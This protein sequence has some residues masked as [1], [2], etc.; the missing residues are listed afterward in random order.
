MR[1]KLFGILL[2]VLMFVTLL[3]ITVFAKDISTIGDVLETVEGGFPTTPD[4]GW[5]SGDNRLFLNETKMDIV[6]KGFDEGS[7]AQKSD[8]VTKSGNSYIFNPQYGATLSFNMSEGDVLTLKSITITEDETYNGT[9]IPQTPVAQIGDSYYYTLSDALADAEKLETVVLL[10]DIDTDEDIIV[11]ELVFLDLNNHTIIT[12]GKVVNNGTIIV[13][14]ENAPIIDYLLYDVLGN[15]ATG[16]ELTLPDSTDPKYIVPYRTFMTAD[17]ND[18]GDQILKFAIG[19]EYLVWNA[20]VKKDTA[21]FVTYSLALGGDLLASDDYE[22]ETIVETT[23]LKLNND[24]TIGSNDETKGYVELYVKDIYDDDPDLAKTGSIDLNSHK[25]TLNETGCLVVFKDIVF[26]DSMVVSGNEGRAVEKLDY[27][28]SVYYYFLANKQEFVNDPFEI[29]EGENKDLEL[30]TT[31][32]Y[33]GEWEVGV[34]IDGSWLN[35]K[36]YDLSHGSIHITLH[37]DYVKTLAPGKHIIKVYTDGYNTISQELIVKGKAPE[38]I[39][40]KTSVR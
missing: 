37:G 22:G 9:Y 27:A 18:Y 16:E 26:D 3:P 14:N 40:P 1:R 36:N 2:S 24:I 13:Y 21:L 6:V 39:V 12:T 4:S 29:N 34:N 11:D 31:G 23:D 19:E 8:E 33:E 10:T 30:V 20:D 5:I 25:I 38:R 17:K 32:E 7:I 35:E 15:F 28:P